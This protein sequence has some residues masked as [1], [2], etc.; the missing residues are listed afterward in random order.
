MY[1]CIYNIYIYIYY[2]KCA[3][4]T[5]PPFAFMARF[6]YKLNV[7][8]RISQGALG[9]LDQASHNKSYKLNKKKESNKRPKTH[10][11]R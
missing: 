2:I 9:A 3:V 7:F 8:K 10:S 5:T 1:V 4:S 11:H 6:P